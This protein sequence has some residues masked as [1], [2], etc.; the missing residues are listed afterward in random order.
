MEGFQSRHAID[1]G[2][3]PGRLPYD[4]QG[5][6]FALQAHQE[7]DAGR[8]RR[9]DE[10]L[11][12][13]GSS[14]G[15]AS[16]AEGKGRGLGKE[17]C[18]GS[19][20]SEGSR[21]FRGEFQE[22]QEEEEKVKERK[23]GKE[24]GARHQEFGLHVREDGLGPRPT[25]EEEDL[26]K[27]STCGQ[28]E[29]SQG[30]LNYI[31]QFI[32]RGE[33]HRGGGFLRAVWGGDESQAG[34]EQVSRE[35]DTECR[36]TTSTSSHPTVRP[37]LGARQKLPSPNIFTILADG[38]G[39]E[40]FEGDLKGNANPSV[41]VRPVVAGQASSCS[42]YSH[43]TAEVPRTDGGWRRL[44]G[45]PEV[46]SCAAGRSIDVFY[47]GDF[48]GKQSS[49]RRDESEE[50]GLQRMGERQRSK[51]RLRYVGCEGQRKEGRLCEG[52]RKRRQMGLQKGRLQKR[53]GER[54]EVMSEALE[55]LDR[56]EIE[57]EVSP[58][59]S[60][61]HGRVLVPTR[62]PPVF[63]EKLLNLKG[64]EAAISDGTAV[65]L[66]HEESK[67]ASEMSRFHYDFLAAK[68]GRTRLKCLVKQGLKGFRLSDVFDVL[69]DVFDEVKMECGVLHSKVQHSGGVFPLPETLS[70]LLQVVVDN[71]VEPQK[72]QCLLAI[73]RA[74]N[75]YYGVSCSGQDAVTVAKRSSVE[76]L[77][78]YAEDV[79]SW[80]EKFDGVSWDELLSTRSIDY[81]GDEVRVS[82]QFRWENIASALPDEVGQIPLT[83]VCD[84]GTLDYVN[85]FED[86]LL[87]L[88]AQVQTKAPRVMV[89]EDS[90]EQVCSGL[91]AKG[92]C[93]LMPVRDLYHIGDSP[94]LNG[95]FGVS[96]DEFVEGVEV[97]RLIMNLIP[98]NKL[99]RNL[100]GDVATLPN[101]SGMGS[102]VLEDGQV[103]LMSSEDIRCF[104]Y[105]FSV[106][107]A[108]KRFLGFNKLVPASLVGPQWR[109]LPCVLVSRVLPMG[110]VNSVSIAQHIHRRVARLGLFSRVKGEAMLGSHCEIRRDQPLPAS[111]AAFRIYLDNFDLLEK[112]DN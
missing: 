70:G 99:C 29:G 79:V 59:A 89:S 69:C 98:V 37:A 82:K 96:K 112:V 32:F 97:M 38:V 8:R 49:T 64:G 102:Y 13:H 68:A 28:K 63:P 33:Q 76:G 17:G 61:W 41:C 18:Q 6:A 12:R 11:G 105:L 39:P 40:G 53:G 20:C 55:K 90:W 25:A 56:P 95:M 94:V 108:W 1:R 54:E 73:S 42:R 36:G 87:P 45:E 48:G 78:K 93:E 19:G 104:F 44:S 84:L 15:R 65:H 80:E 4:I 23:E 43:S 67:E 16:N 77:M 2:S 22:G 83:E 5:R 107:D 60:G 109:G 50:C 46:G 92:I 100:G 30:E 51:R 106:P 85:N 71:E 66:E 72:A 27:G 74:L 75:S 24:E 7:V 110:F 86:Y 3:L 34:L 101:W 103:L 47:G 31:Q 35:L 10:E 9:V 111:K 52:E 26:E 21:V 14:G 62:T 91:L 57:D 88:E 81:K 58:E